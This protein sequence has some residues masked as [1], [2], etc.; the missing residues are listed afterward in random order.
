[1]ETITIAAPPHPVIHLEVNGNTRCKGGG[2]DEVIIQASAAGDISSRVE[3][4]VIYL[5]AES[6]AVIT[7][8][9]DAD[10]RVGTVQGN[11]Q[12]KDLTGP[13]AIQIV[14]G[15]L[16]LHRVGSTTVEKI[17]GN[18]TARE[19]SGKLVLHAVYGNLTAQYVAGRVE[20]RDQAKGNL[21]LREVSGAYATGLGNATLT[22]TPANNDE[23]LV[24][25][26]GNLYCAIPAEA[27]VEIEAWSGSCKFRVDFPERKEALKSQDLSLTR[28]GGD[29]RIT[30]KAKGYVHLSTA[31]PHTDKSDRL[32]P[33]M[34]ENI[35]E[36]SAEIYSLIEAQMENLEQ[37]LN[38][39]LSGLPDFSETPEFSEDITQIVEQARQYSTRAALQA[40]AR[41]QAAAERAQEKLTRKLE[42]ARRRAQR[43]ANKSAAGT[44]VR[45]SWMPG[46]THA[47]RHTGKRPGHR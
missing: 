45:G 28:H 7:L 10:L 35:G 40:Q 18:L 23:Y 16:N 19:V 13:L 39:S 36:I 47:P 24:E 42:K 6:D 37:Q 44:A 46:Q 43:Q 4:S 32:G 15:N 29:S 8:P 22:L 41:A 14:G 34:D 5:T 26:S 25:V 20:L 33:D 9:A 17:Y 12:F 38:D 2:T 30:L 11:G 1:M 27:S 21:I 3:D 31:L